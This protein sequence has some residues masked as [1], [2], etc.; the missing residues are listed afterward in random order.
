MKFKLTLILAL[1]TFIMANAYEY[2]YSFKDTSLP[3]ALIQINRDHPDLNI[4]FIYKYLQDY[5]TS[6]TVNT[7]NAYEAIRQTIGLNP[8]TA[9][10]NGSGFYIEALQNGRF[11]YTGRATGSDGRPI[12]AA[13]VLLL[14]PKDSTVITYG[15]TDDAGHFTIPCDRREVI[16]K[17]TCLGYNPEYRS[18]RT[19]SIGDIIMT[20]R[21]IQ[22]KA[23]NVRSDDALL[24]SDKSVYRPSQRQK[25][26]A[27]TANQLLLMMSIPQLYVDPS[28]LSVKTAGGQPV[29]IFIDGISAT[30]Q[31]L[32]GMRT[33][34]VKRVE[35][36][37]NPQDI[38]FKGAQYAVN[39]IMQKYEWGGY[40][41][42]SAGKWLAADLTNGSVYSK[43]V[44]KKMTY[45]LS[46]SDS[47]TTDRHTG[48]QTSETFR[49]DDLFGK[50]PMTLE[51][52]SDPISS[53]YRNNTANGSLRALYSTPSTQ[54]SN[55][56]QVSSTYIPDNNIKSS[57]TYPDGFLP[58]SFSD[59]ISSWQGF[60]LYDDFNL[61]HS[62]NRKVAF[63]IELEYTYTHNTSNSLYTAPDLSIRNDAGESKHAIKATPFLI[64]KLD[65]HNT[66]MPFMLGEYVPA[67]IDYYGNSPSRQNYNIWDY[68]AGI[69]YVHQRSRWSVAT[70]F[71]WIYGNTDLSGIKTGVS[72]P[73][74]DLSATFSPNRKNQFELRYL[75]RQNVAE[76]YQK[77]PTM[78]RQNEL[79]WY[80]GT[81]DLSNTWYQNINM[82][83]TWIPSGK[84]RF[85]LFG[86]CDMENDRVV[87]IYSPAGPEGTMLRKYM[88][89]GNY[90]K[91]TIGVN[92]TSILLDRTLYIS[93]MPRYCLNTTTGE[94]AHRISDMS[95]SA[96]ITWYFGAFYLSGWYSTP[97]KD[98][99]TGSGAVTHFPSR[100]HLMLGWGKG[101]WQA[102]ATAYNFMSTK[103]EDSRYTL[104]GGY[105][106]SESVNYGINQ[107]MRFQLAATYTFGYGKKVKQDNE[108]NI[109]SQS[110]SL[111]LK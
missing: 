37:V 71:A 81:P 102:S 84:W 51:R 18:C 45:D 88:N 107:H 19:F 86:N 8:V 69:R 77:S 108:I 68:M 13:T 43:F 110:S 54:V 106:S 11:H 17:L 83:Y 49:F 70:H 99:S 66:I 97:M 27:Q 35:F 56:L 60:N 16:A 2:S 14:N 28:T 87:S 59:N 26:L 111:M 34:D 73:Q 101:A 98:F 63:N 80:A 15:I 75:L 1:T 48:S 74:I 3:D 58:E 92:G 21:P 100:Y 10:R 91:Y 72:T 50:G 44:Y 46:V 85:S 94:Y 61:Y 23:V 90:Q 89:D 41:K 105:Y 40:S 6:A 25:N 67:T 9:T 5:R 64:W 22:L 65:G 82:S 53:L 4:S 32:N 12:A 78:L 36:L 24:Y 30:Q 96:Q 7:D 93:L 39:F 38:R 33:N 20:E 57:L 62:I 47:Y 55:Q 52:R 29:S 109:Q 103:W 79:L 76:T 104:S 31:D 42:L 95:C